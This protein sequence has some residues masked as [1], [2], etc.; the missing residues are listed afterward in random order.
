[1]YG[2]A[3][4]LHTLVE[5]IMANRFVYELFPATSMYQDAIKPKVSAGI[6]KGL[7]EVLPDHE[8]KSEHKHALASMT[9][10]KCLNCIK[11]KC[12]F[13]IERE[14]HVASEHGKPTNA[15]GPC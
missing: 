5:L 15:G 10:D 2:T 12:H 9:L 6:F 8:R 1:M 3:Y 4:T 11:V 13:V 14:R 7:Y